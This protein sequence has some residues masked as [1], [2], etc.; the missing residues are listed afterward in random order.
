[1][2]LKYNTLRFV[3]STVLWPGETIKMYVQQSRNWLVRGSLTTPKVVIA[4]DKRLIIM[5][6][7]TFGIRKEYEVIPYNQIAS[8]RMERGILA[9][10]ILI[11][12]QGFGDTSAHASARESEKGDLHGL[13][14]QPAFELADFITKAVNAA[15]ERRPAEEES[16]VSRK[17]QIYC[18]NCGW[19]NAA[20]SKYCNNCGYPVVMAQKQEEAKEIKA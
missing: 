5:N 8:V 1:M 6:R 2:S 17:G 18:S 11:R 20:G 9:S 13:P 16:Q 10:S 3:A 4:T 19:R 15:H 7:T 14:H 12:I